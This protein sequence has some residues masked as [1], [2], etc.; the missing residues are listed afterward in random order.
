[1]FNLVCLYKSVLLKGKERKLSSFVPET[2]SFEIVS[3]TIYQNIL[4]IHVFILYTYAP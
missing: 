4:F 3:V 2:P 1:M